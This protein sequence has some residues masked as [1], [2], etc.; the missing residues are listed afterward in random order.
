MN[1]RWLPS[2]AFL[3]AILLLSGCVKPVLTMPDQPPQ[4]VKSYRSVTLQAGWAGMK[5]TGVRLEDGDVYSLFATGRMDYCP[6]GGCESRNVTPDLGWPL[7]TRVGDGSYRSP[8]FGRRLGILRHAD[9]DGDL[10]VGYRQGPLQVDGTPRRPDWYRNDIGAFH[11]DVVVWARDDYDAIVS[12]LETMVKRTPENVALRDGLE[13]AR[14][15][16]KIYA[17]AQKAS[18]AIEATKEEI[19][20]LKAG[21][22][23][24]EKA[25]VGERPVEP[26]AGAAGTGTEEAP[27]PAPAADEKKQ[28]RIAAL[29]A[30]LA[31]LQEMLA[32]FEKM[33]QSLAEERQKTEQLSQ[34]LGE[35]EQ[36]EKDLQV[37]LE[38]GDKTPPVVVIA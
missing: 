6:Q 18:E 24:W 36:R 14:D 3:L 34:E 28:G 4:I 11:V 10:Y 1:R 27:P 15:W 5:N 20:T 8:F 33:Q 16:K 35:M 9:G 12:F 26:A 7:I 23:E 30:R 38:E 32:E 22:G 17:D 13:Y 37:R 19:A 25:G 21:T 31:R 2:P 29:E